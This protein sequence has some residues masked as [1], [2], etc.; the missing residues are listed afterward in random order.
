MEAIL[1]R[2]IP[3]TFASV[4]VVVSPYGVLAGDRRK[5][6]GGAASFAKRL[7]DSFHNKYL[8]WFKVYL[9]LA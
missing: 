2:E 1:K 3:E 7:A 9:I 6:E 4:E 8:R 5:G